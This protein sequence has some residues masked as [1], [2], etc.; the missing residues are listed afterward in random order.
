VTESKAASLPPQGSN[1][2]AA[3]YARK[4]GRH[5]SRSGHPAWTFTATATRPMR[6]C[7]RLLCGC[8]RLP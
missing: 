6:V 1:S 7:L 8:C 3:D 4:K 2:D 5:G